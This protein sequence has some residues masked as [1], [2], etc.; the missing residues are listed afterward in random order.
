M[1]E[2]DPDSMLL[3]PL[4]ARSIPSRCLA[5]P[6]L[7]FIGVST[8]LQNRSTGNVEGELNLARWR[9]KIINTKNTANNWNMSTFP[10]AFYYLFKKN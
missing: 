8:C 3:C 10:V 2:Q 6:C 5:C 9:S 4:V 7:G 1:T